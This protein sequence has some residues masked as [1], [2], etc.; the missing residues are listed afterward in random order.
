M[1]N[2]DFSFDPS[3]FYPIVEPANYSSQ[4]LPETTMGENGATPPHLGTYS[5]EMLKTPPHLDCPSSKNSQEKPKTTDIPASFEKSPVNSVPNE[6]VD[7][8][9]FQNSSP[10]P[11][12]TEE[13]IVSEARD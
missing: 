13:K 8:P 4:T 9:N 2:N 1:W 10:K 12:L 7:F 3:L 6:N 11:T 5:S